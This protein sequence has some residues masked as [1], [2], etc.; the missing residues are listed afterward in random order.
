MVNMAVAVTWLLLDCATILSVE[1]N[2]VKKRCSEGIGRFNNINMED[3]RDDILDLD[4]D[5]EEL[6]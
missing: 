2:N 4:L 1:I 6:R 5:L 3:N